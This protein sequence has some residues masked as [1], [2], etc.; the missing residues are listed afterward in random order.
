MDIIIFRIEIMFW[1]LLE[2]GGHEVFV[3]QF[4]CFKS[5]YFML[6]KKGVKAIGFNKSF[7][8]FHPFD[9]TAYFVV[10]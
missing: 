1:I 2:K 3:V 5:R 6:K 8:D 4:Y 9:E 7:P 10:N